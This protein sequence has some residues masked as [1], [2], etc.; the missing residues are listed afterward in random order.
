M[1][2]ILLI[3]ISLI[4]FTNQDNVIRAQMANEKGYELQ[5]MGEVRIQFLQQATIACL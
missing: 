1:T 5:A 2:S 3:F 4:G